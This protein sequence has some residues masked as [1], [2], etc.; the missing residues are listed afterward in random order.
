[1][2]DSDS[3]LYIV[4]L[5]SRRCVL[6]LKNFLASA[7][8]GPLIAYGE[9]MNKASPKPWTSPDIDTLEKFAR[10]GTPVAQIAERLGR[11]TDAVKRKARELGISLEPP[12]NS[13]YAKN[14]RGTTSRV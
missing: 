1:M 11:K 9:C 2:F 4:C 3:P 14:F 6:N 10:G 7:V 5:P 13:P 12:S 8:I